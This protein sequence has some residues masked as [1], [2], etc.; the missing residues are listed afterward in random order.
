MRFGQMAAI[1]DE[2]L[3][4]AFVQLSVAASTL[5]KVTCTGAN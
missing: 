4:S 5:S 2:R 3:G 1:T